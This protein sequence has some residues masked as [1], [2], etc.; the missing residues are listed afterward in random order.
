MAKPFDLLV[1]GELNPDLILADPALTPRFG[2]QEILVESATLAIGSSS[3]IFACGAAR[4]GLRVAFI[5]VVGDDLFG[6]F[7]LEGLSAR[8][9]DVSHVIVDPAQK[10]GLSVIL[11]RGTDR[12][13]LTHLGAIQALRAEQVPDSLLSAARHLHVASHFL[14]ANL[15]P[16]L[17]D[18]FSTA[19]VL[20]MTTSLDTNWDPS[21]EWQGVRRLLQ[22]TNIFF[23][24]EAEALAL[25][26]AAD[27]AGAME[28]LAADGPFVVLAVKRGALGAA[29]RRGDQTVRVGVLPGEVA[30]TV[31]AGD[32]F[33]AGFI[34]GYLQSWD[35]ARCLKAG[36]VCGT[37][38]TR[39]YGGTAA[40]AT[41]EE[42]LQAMQT[43]PES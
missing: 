1:A 14:Q 25:T 11:S 30:D 15:Q 41:L 18:L 10:T 6:R 3:A 2:Q 19:M 21:G 39:A 4:L 35:L 17:F 22:V 38:S 13:I 36:V 16:G 8:G 33:D 34:Y 43:L 28:I 9:V 5:G 29:A 27:L 40:Q 26:G 37:L 7:M 42:A 31:G 23:P 32:S 24:N 20:G 12:A